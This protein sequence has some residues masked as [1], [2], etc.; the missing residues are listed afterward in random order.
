M[1]WEYPEGRTLRTEWVSR[2]AVPAP[3]PLTPLPRWGEGNRSLLG[4]AEERCHYIL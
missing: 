2:K 4:I 1:G 3:L